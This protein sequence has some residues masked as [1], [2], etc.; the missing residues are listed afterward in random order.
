[1]TGNPP[2][3]WTRKWR[4]ANQARL[5]AC[6][7]LIALLVGAPGLSHRA[8]AG[9]DAGVDSL[10][11][12]AF[13]AIPVAGINQFTL[14][15]SEG[16]DPAHLALAKPNMNAAELSYLTPVQMGSSGT[17]PMT[18]DTVLASLQQFDSGIGTNGLTSSQLSSFTSLVA[19]AETADGS[20]SYVGS[21]MNSMLNSGIGVGTSAAQ[22]TST[23]D[24]WFLG[25]DNPAINSG[26]SYT[27]VA[28]QSLFSNVPNA[29]LQNQQGQI[30]DCWLVSSL[31][32][33]AAI[34]PSRLG[35]LI[36][37]NGNGTYA[38]QFEDGS[39]NNPV[40]VTVNSQV[41]SYGV[42]G[43]ASWTTLAETAYFE[44]ASD[45][46]LT[47]DKQPAITNSYAAITS[48]YCR[49]ALQTLTGNACQVFDT[50]N[51][52]LADWTGT[53]YNTVVA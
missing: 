38:V 24:Q 10:S 27:N 8:N 6:L 37:N 18:Y 13:A 14:A 46:S 40:F 1:M 41:A 36:G 47:G 33:M 31:D 2:L 17:N 43:P 16:L 29:Y 12:A 34:A 4:I 45:G 48:G 49:V 3:L 23:L 15:A 19:A 25:T 22:F 50:N 30:G 11:L 42:S 9:V 53:T 5:V 26:A 35:S 7:R 44:A 28:G 21:L 20:K 51:E 39:S 32:D 52:S